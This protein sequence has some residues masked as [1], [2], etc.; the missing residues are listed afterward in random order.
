MIETIQHK[1]EGLSQAEWILLGAFTLLFLMRT[2]YLFVFTGRYLFLKKAKPV[3]TQE[4]GLSLILTIR[5]EEERLRRTLPGILQLKD[6]DFEVVAVDDFSHDNS[7]LVL[8][9][10]KERS[11]RLHI[12]G[13]NQETR[14]SAKLAQNLALKAAKNEWALVVPVSFENGNLPWLQQMA[15]ALKPGKDVVVG[16]ST[17]K[18]GKGTANH[19]F[20]MENFWMSVKSA[21]FI[22]NGLPFVYNEENIAFRRSKYFETG[23]YGQKIKEP[24]A[25]LELL[26]N[27]FI[28]K[29]TATVLFLPETTILKSE[30]PGWRDYFDLLKKAVRIE[31]H[32]TAG[33]RF[34]LATESFSRMFFLPIAISVMVLFPEFWPITVGLLSL[35][36]LAYLFIIKTFQNRLN[37]RKIFISSLVYDWLVPYFKFFYRLYFNHQSKK[38]RWRSKA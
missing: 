18:S 17:I 5:N 38:N 29:K 32:L 8:G 7:Y 34:A 37:E 3:S 1:L 24:F 30:E 25:N 12:S 23:G 28:R 27:R 9:M 31:K 22:L 35:K 21:G 26:I 19:F 13:L 6:V 14:Y 10:L 20:R 2:W 16:Y 4:S 11:E 33:K 15:S 36:L